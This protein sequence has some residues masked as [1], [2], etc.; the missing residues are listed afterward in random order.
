M[1]LSWATVRLAGASVPPLA[2]SRDSSSTARRRSDGLEVLG[3]AAL[4]RLHLALS[5]IPLLVD[6]GCQEALQ[7]FGG[8]LAKLFATEAAFHR[9]WA[10]VRTLHTAQE[11][12]LTLE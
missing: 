1:S 3:S 4:V 10:E 8:E 9:E 2:A 12:A 7:L 6:R 11:R 5:A